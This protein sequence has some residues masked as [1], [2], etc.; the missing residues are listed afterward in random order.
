VLFVAGRR[1]T[2][3]LDIGPRPAFFEV[4]VLGGEAE[5]GRVEIV[6]DPYTPASDGGADRRT[7]GVVLSE[8]AFEPGNHGS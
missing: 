7:L 5:G 4:E 6:S 1:A 3:P 8:V 2:G